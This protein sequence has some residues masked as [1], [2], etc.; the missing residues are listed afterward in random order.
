MAGEQHDPMKPGG[1]VPP[2]VPSAGQEPCERCG[3][4]G[5]LDGERCRDCHGTGRVERPVGG[6]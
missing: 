5:E 2:D 6:G 4:T 3:G 1:E